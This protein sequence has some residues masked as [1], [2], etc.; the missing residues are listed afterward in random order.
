MDR[1]TWLK[2][3]RRPAEAR[4]DARWAPIYDEN[5]G[6]II[7]LSHQQFFAKFLRM[8]RPHA[9][10]LDAACG[11]GKYWSMILGSGRT[12]FGIDQSLGMLACAQKKFPNVKVEKIGLQEMDFHASFDAGICMD[13]MECVFPE[14]WLHVLQNIHRALQPNGYFYF[15]VEMAAENEI[16]EAFKSAQEKGLP[17][18]HGEW[19]DEDGYHYY[20]RLE[21]V[22]TWVREA[23]FHLIEE[24]FGD[25]YQHFLVQKK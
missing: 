19:A 13:A 7:E 4:Y 25:L 2:G 16:E 12:V 10:I 11:T 21:Q 23:G 9:R 8:C 15:T 17:V 22:R 18:V 24:F 5:W 14:D 3:I 6:S 1:S 20:P